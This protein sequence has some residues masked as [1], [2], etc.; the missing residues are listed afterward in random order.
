[1]RPQILLHDKITHNFLHL[2]CHFSQLYCCHCW[3]TS[4]LK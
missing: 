3:Q 2:W 4:K 1:L